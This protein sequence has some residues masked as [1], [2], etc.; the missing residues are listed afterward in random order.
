MQLADVTTN[1][2]TVTWTTS[3]PTSSWLD[4]GSSATYGTSLG[5]NGSNTSHTAILTGLTPG[6]TYHYRV[7][8]ITGDGDN[9]T[10]DDHTFTTIALPQITNVEAS[11][12]T[13]NA[14]TIT[15]TTNIATDTLV[16]F[17]K[18]QEYEKKQ[19]IQESVT[20]HSLTILGLADET[21]FHFSIEG[22]DEA[23]NVATSPDY[24][25]N[26]PTDSV[27]PKIKQVRTKVV[28]ARG[29]GEKAM[30]II[31]WQTDEPA[32]TQIEYQAGTPQG[33]KYQKETPK[34]D[35]YN[36]SHTEMISNLKPST[37]YHFRIVTTDKRG[38]KSASTDQTVLTPAQ[39]QSVMDMIMDSLEESFFWVGRVRAWIMDK[40]SG[41]KSSLSE[42]I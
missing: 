5:Q 13:Y 17:G 18:T 9:L 1:A 39:S 23:G 24:V 8:G 19:G 3:I 33:D 29:E 14:A 40:W 36:V 37:A 7:R 34:D 32:N 22:K 16:R 28:R 12:V 20:D 11:D 4:Y 25:F 35:S 15:W 26:T 42:A 27:G 21:E 38:N 41:L 30:A 31:T 10:G 2:A 6:T